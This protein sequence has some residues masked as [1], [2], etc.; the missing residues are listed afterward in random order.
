MPTVLELIDQTR[1]TWMTQAEFIKPAGA[2]GKPCPA[3]R[4]AGTRPGH[5]P[6]TMGDGKD[7]GGTGSLGA[8]C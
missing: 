3:L 4:P 6:R 8:A 5:L 1:D 2:V 7:T